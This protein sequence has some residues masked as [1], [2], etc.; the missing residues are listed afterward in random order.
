MNIKNKLYMSAITSVV[1][2]VII[3][4]LVLVTSNRIAEKSKQLELADEV[5]RAV[6]ELDIVT[7]EYLLHHEERMEEQWNLRY[8]SMAEILEEE[9]EAM[10]SICADYI[11]LGDLFSQV[12]ANYKERQNL[13]QG[14]AAQE[15]ID[16]NI[17]L[18]ERLVSHLLIKSQSLITDASKLAKTASAELMDAQELFST[19]ILI[20]M[21]ILAVIVTVTAIVV[22]RSISKPL[23]N[24]MKGAEIVGKGNLEHKIVSETKDEVGELALAFNNMAANLKNVTASRDDLN[25]EVAERKEREEELKAHREHSRLINKILR[26]DIINDLTVINSALRLYGSTKEEELLKEASVYVNKSVELI[27]RMRELELFISSHRGLKWYSVTDVFNKVIVSYPDIAFNIDGEGQVLADESLSSVIDNIIRNAVIHGKTDR[28]DVNIVERDKYC[29]IRIADYGV[30]ITD[31][32]KE[33]IFEESFVFGETGGTGLGLY[34]VK[35]AMETYGGRVRVEDN[36]PGGTVFVLALR[37]V[38]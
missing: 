25:K 20:L 38:R 34:I 29:E 11:V 26:H 32:I 31:E 18:E 8:G 10:K 21:I 2:I 22:A 9:E 35:K 33:Q 17:L 15:K 24:L 4:S 5:H 19:L 3:F 13:I 36:T 6:S 12:T 23:D 16:A 37:K 7:Y 14:G 27:N 1:L 30:G 28:I